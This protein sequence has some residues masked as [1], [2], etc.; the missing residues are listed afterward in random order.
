MMRLTQAMMIA[1]VTAAILPAAAA[2]LTPSAI[3]ANPSSFDGKSVSVAGSVAKYQTSKTLMG[4]VAAFQLCDAKCV[5]VIDETNTAHK[6]GDTIT[7]AGT[8][9][10]AFKGPRR[11]FKNVVLI[12]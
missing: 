5:V 6:D 10:T 7:V 11:S 3:L 8:F 9:Q 1:F 2:D 12:K 4:T